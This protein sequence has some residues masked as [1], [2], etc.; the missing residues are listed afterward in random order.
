[1]RTIKSAWESFEKK[2]LPPEAG[3]SQRY[4]M[5]VSFYAGAVT[6]ANI[7]AQIGEDHIDEQQAMKILTDIQI[8]LNEAVKE[9]IK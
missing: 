3:E 8:E 1:M 9:F 2:C 4:D 7:N 5:K 6:M